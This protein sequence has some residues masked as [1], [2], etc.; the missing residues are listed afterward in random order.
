MGKQPVAQNRDSE[1]VP[2][3]GKDKVLG[4]TLGVKQLRERSKIM[5]EE[6]IKEL[7]GQDVCGVNNICVCKVNI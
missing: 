6:E 2:D 7:K 4:M 1:V 3:I 5:G